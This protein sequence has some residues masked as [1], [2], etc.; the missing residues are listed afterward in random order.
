M[1]IQL[2]LPILH[3]YYFN[4]LNGHPTSASSE[5]QF[6]VTFGHM[7]G[8]GSNCLGDTL[9]STNNGNTLNGETEAIYRQWGI[10][11]ISKAIYR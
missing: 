6:S 8:S 7:L 9:G 3:T 11:D 10:P 2:L 1:S 5:V 4:A